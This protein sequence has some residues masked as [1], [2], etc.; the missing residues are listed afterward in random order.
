MP[1]FSYKG[2]NTKGES[3]RGEVTATDRNRVVEQLVNQNI[4]PVNIKEM[5][6][7]TPLS[8]GGGWPSDDDRI[9]FC[10]Q[11]YTLL[12]AGIPVVRAIHNIR[13]SS[14]NQRLKDAL[15]AIAADLESGKDI[16]SA[17]GSHPKVF[18][19]LFANI[20][21]VGETSGRL[22]ES[23][24]QLYEFLEVDKN[25]RQQ[26]KSALRY[27]SIVLG[28]TF[29]VLYLLN[30]YVI[31]SFDKLFKQFGAELPWQTRL[32]VTTSDFT[33]HHG[34][35]MIVGIIVSI[36]A[37]RKYV[38]TPGG[39]LWWDRKKLRIPI[40]GKI[41]EQATLARFAR[42]F[43]MCLRSGMPVD[44]S[45]NIVGS[46][47]DNALIETGI[48][49]MQRRINRGE[50]ILQSARSSGMFT[51]LVLQM[52]AVGDETGRTDEMMQSV[53]TY[54]EREVAYNVKNLSTAIE[55][56]L[57]AMMG[58]IVLIL[59]LGIFMPMWGMGKAMGMKGG[60]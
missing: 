23:I 24:K 17:M 44:Q 25:T 16:A 40:I 57:M 1:R 28:A 35:A 37:F 52:L 48:Q 20:I 2:R 56:I 41:V 49:E 8:L 46:S 15:E 42:T 18:P 43:A 29:I 50:S 51:R 4:A 12:D 7:S 36:I 11:I 19:R 38:E 13:E 9:Q 22:P 5:A 39:R 54:Y 27:P 6:I 53:A 14:G 58:G 10:R 45:L 32:L 55:P 31:P 47:I 60:G 30:A 21:R 34:P 59:A 3:V 26:I 33:I